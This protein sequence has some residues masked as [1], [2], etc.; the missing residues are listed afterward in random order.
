M[1]TVLWEKQI[2]GGRNLHCMSNVTLL[3]LILSFFPAFARQVS[4]SIEESVAQLWK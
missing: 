3:C 4:K 1:G 2:G